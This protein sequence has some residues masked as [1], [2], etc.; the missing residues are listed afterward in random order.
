[1]IDFATDTAKRVIDRSDLDDQRR[2]SQLFQLALAR[3]PTD[4]EVDSILSYIS[5]GASAEEESTAGKQ[6]DQH[7]QRWVG[8][9]QTILASSEFRH[10]K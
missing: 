5:S 6:T 2:L 10:L 9:C 4:Q 1:M 8:V 7:F 3:K